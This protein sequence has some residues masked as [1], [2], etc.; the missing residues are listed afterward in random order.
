MADGRSEEVV[1]NKQV[2]LRD[3]VTGFPK[4]TDMYISTTS[5]SLKAL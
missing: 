5:I 3:Y 4:E 2:I 1:S